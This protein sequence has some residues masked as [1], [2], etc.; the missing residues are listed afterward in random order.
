MNKP[1]HIMDT[2]E[3]GELRVPCLQ[4]PQNNPSVPPSDGSCPIN[5][6]PPEI[7]SLIFE[8]GTVAAENFEEVGGEGA[9]TWSEFWEHHAEYEGRIRRTKGELDVLFTFPIY[10]LPRSTISGVDRPP[11][12][13]VNAFLARSKSLPLDIYIDSELPDDLSDDEDV[14]TEL[15]EA[16]LKELLALLVPHVPRWGSIEVHVESYE[17]MYTLLKTLSDP[18]VPPAS[19]LQV[20]RLYHHEESD[21][22]ITTFPKSEFSD[23]LTLFSGCA[24]RL[25]NVSLWGLELAYHTPGV[26]P[27]W[28]TFSA[29]LRVAA[30]T[31]ERMSLESSGP[32]GSPCEWTIEPG[33]RDW[34]LSHPLRSIS[35]FRRLCMP[36][37]KALTLNLDN[38]DYTDLVTYLAKT[39]DY[40]RYHRYRCL[41]QRRE[42]PRSF[43]GGLEFLK[44]AGLPCSE[45]SVEKMY[46]ELVNLDAL[47]LGPPDTTVSYRVLLPRLTTLFISNMPGYNVQRFVHE[48][49]WVGVPL[50]MVFVEENTDI[51]PEEENWLKENLEK[52]DYFEGS[53]DEDV[54]E[55]D[56]VSS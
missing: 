43:L 49:Q 11:Y 17:H 29:M 38:G 5:R 18:S 33:T 4:E 7:L 42:Q 41:A 22:D 50:R 6:L 53:D 51:T 15:S 13:R 23:H 9:M 37:L 10:H 40:C 30:P 47:N 16:D 24:P 45:Q 26:R 25:Q 8:H 35:L 39:Y 28:L 19:Q 21:G 52:F 2:T 3:N 14:P 32:S 44:I 36:S 55:D 46:S 20:F 1:D 12:E 48:R 54:Y 34:G 56:S 27:N 31:L